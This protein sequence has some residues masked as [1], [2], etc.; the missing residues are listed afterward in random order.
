MCSNPSKPGNRVWEALEGLSGRIDLRSGDGSIRGRLLS[1]IPESFDGTLDA[2]T[3][4]GGIAMH[5]ISL[6]KVTGRMGRN[7]ARGDLGGGGR[8]VRIRTGDG[9][10]TLRRQ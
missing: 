8:P 6:S 3:G 1:G 9:S 4:D 10:I 5:G 2:H 7:T